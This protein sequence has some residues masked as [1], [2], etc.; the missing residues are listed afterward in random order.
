MKITL[1]TPMLN[2]FDHISDRAVSPAALP[3]AA[4]SALVSAYQANADSVQISSAAR[5]MNL[6]IDTEEDGDRPAMSWEPITNFTADKTVSLADEHI[7]K[8]GK[9]LE[10]MKALAEAAQDESLSDIDR[11]DLQIEMG[12]LQ[13]ELNTKADRMAL[14]REGGF[15]SEKENGAPESVENVIKERHGSFED[16][17][18]YKMLQR[19][20]ERIAN[21]EEWD[22]SEIASDIVK[23]EDGEVIYV[24]TDWEISDDEA[25]Q[26]V[27]DILKAKGM[28]VM[29]PE[30]AALTAKKL[31]RDL[32]SLA[33]KREELVAFAEKNGMNQLESDNVES[34]LK[35]AGAL[36]FKLQ[37]F[38]GTLSKDM[39]QTT[40]GATKDEDGNFA[41]G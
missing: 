2:N 23:I 10:R 22:V 34:F 15:S 35:E 16:S 18:A 11:V 32:A 4:K 33:K 36:A 8:T 27:G 31:D 39:N 19:A 40:Y 1:N 41:G 26:T 29:D 13:H 25:V 5:Q 6:H 7:S 30:S 9:L 17:D 28:S 14:G 20:R 38:L 24:R 21:G 37:R 3:G 12:R